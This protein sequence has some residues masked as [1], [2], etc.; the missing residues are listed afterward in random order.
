MNANFAAVETAVNDNDARLAQLEQNLSQID[1]MF[2]TTNACPS[3]Y[4]AVTDG[5]IK[6]G[7]TGL[8]TSVLPRTLSLPGH[9][10]GH[11]LQTDTYGGHD[12]QP[13]FQEIDGANPGGGLD[14]YEAEILDNDIGSHLH[15][16]SGNIGS[17]PSG[18]GDIS[19]VGAGE[20]ERVVLRLC[21]RS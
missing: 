10:H 18:D 16:V 1:Q 3:G 15:N 8:T 21:V 17:G 9:S 12:G 13:F 6:L 2:L 5:Y 20:L 7:A 14:V 11:T 4:V 19:L